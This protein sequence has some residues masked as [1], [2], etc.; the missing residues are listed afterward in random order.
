MSMLKSAER[1]LLIAGLA[2]VTLSALVYAG[3]LLQA[4]LALRAFSA[5][6]TQAVEPGVASHR[7]NGSH[8]DVSL[9][10][11]ER[12]REYESSLAEQFDAPVAVLR[13][14]RIHLEVPVFNGTDDQI[15]NRG[16]GR[17]LGTAGPGER[18]N[19]GIAGHRD[20]FFRGLKDIATADTVQLVTKS[21][22]HT[23]VVDWL[24]I[25]SP[26]DIS[27]LR[28][29][30]TPTLTLVTCYPFYFI[31]SAPKRFIV[32]ASMEVMEANSMNRPGG[33]R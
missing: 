32:H 15:L 33:V 17:I 27:V 14:S 8:V 12:I 22:T 23:Y 16:V 25:V 10:S 1:V 4:R 3:G 18:G 5:E 9:W 13:I 20:G 19:I 2:L 11:E 29:D 26:E 28:S 6:V 31:G 7:R 21:G 30:R 24:R